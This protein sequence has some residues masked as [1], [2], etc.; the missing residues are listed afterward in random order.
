MDH[1]HL[2]AAQAVRV[3]KSISFLNIYP[4]IPTR[5]TFSFRPAERATVNV[6]WKSMARFHVFGAFVVVA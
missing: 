1:L 6:A 2:D 5:F 4:I 3:A